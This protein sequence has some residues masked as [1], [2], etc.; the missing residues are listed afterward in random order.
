MVYKRGGSQCSLTA[1]HNG[2]IYFVRNQSKGTLEQNEICNLTQHI[3]F[4]P[5]SLLHR[6]GEKSQGKCK[7]KAELKSL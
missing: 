3:V 4:L 5:V 2:S 7:N 6:N 1:S